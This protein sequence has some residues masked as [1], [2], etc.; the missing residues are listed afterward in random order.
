MFYVYLIKSIKN[1]EKTYI[2]VTK[3]L[4]ARL[5]VHN[6]DGSPHT[7]KYSPWKLISYIAFADEVKAISFETYLKSG[8][9]RAFS[10]KRLW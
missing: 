5:R 2:G 8:S 7:S 3:D 1:P 9:G 6:T 10:K 4:D